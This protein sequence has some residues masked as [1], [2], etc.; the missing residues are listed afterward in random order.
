MQTISATPAVINTTSAATVVSND[1]QAATAVQGNKSVASVL[2]QLVLDRE[3]WE[4]NSYRTSN[5][6]LYGLIQR[7]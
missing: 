7:C 1:T 2:E 3:A 4:Q 5:D 6:Q